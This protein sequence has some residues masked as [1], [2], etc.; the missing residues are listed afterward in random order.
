MPSV[1]SFLGALQPPIAPNLQLPPPGKVIPPPGM[2]LADADRAELTAAVDALGKKLESLKRHPL[3]ADVAVFHKAVQWSLADNTIYNAREVQAAREQLT[4][5]MARAEAL[6]RG[7]TPWTKQTGLV[8]RGYVSKLDGSIQPYGLVVPENAFDGQN[9]RLDL[10]LHGRGENLT[11]L[12]FVDQRRKNPG[13]FTPPGALVLHPYGRFCNANHLA[14]EVDVFEAIRHVQKNYKIDSDRIVLRG[15]SMGGGAAWHLCVHHA[16]FWAA[17]AP[18]AGFSETL[19]FVRIKAPQPDYIYKLMKLYDAT[20]WAVNLAQCPLIVYSGELDGQRQ[21]AVMME[22]A[23]KAEGLPMTHIIGPGAGHFYHKESKPLINAEIDKAIA[24][25][26]N[27][28]PEK[29]RFTTWTLR[30]PKQNWVTVTGLEKHW[31]RGR[32]DAERSADGSSVTLKTSGVTAL[33]LALKPRSVTIDGQ[34]LPGGTAFWRDPNARVAGG[35]WKPGQPKGIWKKPGL[36]G[37]I[38]DAFMERF[39]FVR[40]TG[41]PLTEALGAW[42]T[43]ALATAQNDWHTFFRGEA[44]TIDDT[45]VTDEQIKNANLVLFGDPSSNAVLRRL[46]TKLPVSWGTDGMIRLRGKTYANAVPVLIFPNPLNPTKYVVIN[47]GYTWR[48]YNAGNNAL[49]TPK[50]PD[51][52]VLPLAGGPPLDAGFF[53]ES[54]R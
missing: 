47:S 33:T 46:V 23:L 13:E 43:S 54:W 35:K 30:Y 2:A 7:E 32:V 45:K 48:D 19:E 44:P 25:G 31:E 24:N 36:Q 53:N 29:I 16:D 28:N 22:A 52:A 3:Y 50:L 9:H 42:S 18:G 20:D 49:H 21:A 14:G 34:V 10:F 11:E 8:V 37:P 41:K 15:F 4:E 1:L 38:D 39:V 17:A 40:P 6:L 26:R 27:K 12:A 51:W 5:G